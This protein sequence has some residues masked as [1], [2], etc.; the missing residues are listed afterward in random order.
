MRT[1]KTAL[2]EHVVQ[3]TAAS[4]GSADIVVNNAVVR[5]FNPIDPFKT[6]DRDTVLAVNLSATF[7]TI[8]L[9]ARLIAFLCGPDGRDINGAALPIDGGWSAGRA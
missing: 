4:L 7:H 2:M 1:G 6:E 5:Y 3:A 8:R 9:A